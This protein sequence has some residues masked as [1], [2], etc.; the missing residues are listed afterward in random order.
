MFCLKMS[1]ECHATC[2]QIFDKQL[3]QLLLVTLVIAV[4]DME[5]VIERILHHLYATF[6]FFFLPQKMINGCL[7]NEFLVDSIELVMLIISTK[8]L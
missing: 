5:I 3:T 1:N 7:Q 8:V 6:L 4:S 2:R